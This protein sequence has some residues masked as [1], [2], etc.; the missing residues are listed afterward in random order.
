MCALL[1]AA[2][3]VVASYLQVWSLVTIRGLFFQ[4]YPFGKL[5]ATCFLNV[6]HG[7]IVFQQHLHVLLGLCALLAGIFLFY[8]S[9]VWSVVTIRGLFFQLDLF[10][11]LMATCFLNAG[12]VNIVFQQ[13]LY[14]LLLLCALSAGIFW[15]YPFQFWLLVAITVLF[16]QLNPFGEPIAM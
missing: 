2:S 4:L 6:G 15:F 16:L 12:H 1:S 11:E 14:V 7:I 3:N 13:H 10:G 8:T 5:I 9:Q